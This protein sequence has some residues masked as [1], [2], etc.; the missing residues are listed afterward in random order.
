[1]KRSALQVEPDG[2]GG[3][4][5]DLARY[6]PALLIHTSN[7]MST[8]ANAIYRRTFGVGVTEWRVLA[9]L[10]IE[11]N[12]PAQRICEMIGFD[13]AIVSRVVKS[14]QARGEVK[15]TPDG[16]DNRRRRIALTAKG[17]QLHDRVIVFALERERRLLAGFSAGEVQV[18]RG[19]LHRLHANLPLA[20]G[21]DPA[22]PAGSS[23]E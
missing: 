4:V 6:V 9:L 13:K 21:Y 19:L 12:V 7:K 1:M 14:L 22:T 16:A 2:H 17:R 15:V 10:A 8:G 23:K 20:N 5:L 3:T 18:L 11:P